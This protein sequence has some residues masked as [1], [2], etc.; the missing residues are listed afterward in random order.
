MVIPKI[1]NNHDVHAVIL[2]G[3][4]GRRLGGREKA[5][6]PFRGKPLVFWVNKVLTEQVE[7]V[8]LN[9]NG[10]KALYPSCCPNLFSDQLS[11][12]LGPMLGMVSAFQKVD[13]EWILFVPCDNP[14][15]PKNLLKKFINVYKEEGKSIVVAHDGTRV[16]PLYCLMHRSNEPALIDSLEKRE[17]SIVKWLEGRSV[18]Y[19]SFVKDAEGMFAN[20]NTIDALQ[21]LE[22]SAFDVYPSD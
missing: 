3:G 2:A 20:L 13:S 21:R 1:I 9:A 6:L 4:Q 11:E 8:W 18:S 15:L 5:L 22:D 7:K 16:Q 17:L 19:C 14:F 10:E 12:S